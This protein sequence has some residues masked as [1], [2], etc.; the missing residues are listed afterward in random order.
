VDNIKVATVNLY[1]SATTPLYQQP[2]W[3]TTVAGGVHK[4]EIRLVTT[5]K[6]ISIDRV[7]VVGSLVSAPPTITSLSPTSGT[8][9]G[10]NSVVINGT[11]FTDLSGAAAVTFGGINALSY[12]VNSSTKITATAPAHAA[13]TVQVRVTTGGGST[14]DTTADNY[15]Y[16]VP[17]VTPTRYEQTDGRLAYVGNWAPY[18]KDLA[19]GGSY[20]RANSSANS[21][22]IYFNGT[23]FAWIAMKGTTTGKADVY[24]DDVFQATINL[25]RPEGAVYKQLVWSKTTTAGNHKVQIRANA[26]N[27][28][29]YVTID[30]VEIVGTLLAKP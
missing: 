24:L 3:S 10:G 19:Y 20:G 21:V 14:P 27:G 18:Y 13:G 6:F 29:K 4:V 5:G 11:G 25:Y 17:G 30:A 1:S 12:T 15:T 22:T 26:A 28:T 8:T 9:A 16:V 2:V 23:Q 7:D